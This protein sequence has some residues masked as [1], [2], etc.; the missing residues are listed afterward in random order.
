MSLS[1]YPIPSFGGLNLIGDP[2][3]VGAQ[4]AIDILNIDLDKPGVSHIRTR[5][6]YTNFTATPDTTHEYDSISPFYKTDGT[7]QMLLAKY[8]DGTDARYAAYT[9]AGVFIADTVLAATRECVDTDFCRYGGPSAEV[10]YVLSWRSAARTIANN[11]YKWDGAAWTDLGGGVFPQGAYALEVQATDNRLVATSSVSNYSRVRFSDAGAPETWT[12]TSF[13]DLTPG[14]GERITALCSW[15]ELVFAFKESKFFIFTGNS[16]GSLGLPDFNYRSVYGG[17]GCI[18]RACAIATPAGVYFLSRRG[19]YITNG[20]DPMLVS[21]AIDPI[22]Q[23]GVKPPFSST[24]ELNYDAI[25]KCAFHW[26]QERLYFSYPAGSSTVNNRIL[27]YDPKNSYWTLWDI[28]ANRMCTFRPD[29][30]EELMFTYSTGLNH[31][32]RHSSAYTTDA[33]TDIAAQYQ[34]GFYQLAPGG[35]ATTRWTKIWGTGEP[36]FVMYND[37]VSSDSLSRSGTVT[38]G[39]SPQVAKGYH[40]KSYMGELFSHRFSSTSGAWSIN[41][42]EHDIAQTEQP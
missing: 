23:G 42:V 34:S 21:R 6:G 4:E 9:S 5:D 41:R 15:R 18:G 31:I 8:Y 1:S 38:L 17:T 25:D 13:V 30:E 29:D 3:E 10:V 7:K 19:I 2:E 14:D 28:G 35:K 32:G 26:H 33:G 16:P 27:V 24:N 39:T 22:F 20:D 37:H 11:P 12:S 40:L 36:T